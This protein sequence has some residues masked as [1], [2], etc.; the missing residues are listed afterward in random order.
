MTGIGYVEGDGS[1]GHMYLYHMAPTSRSYG[2]ILIGVEGSKPGAYDQFGHY[3]GP[4]ADSGDV[5]PTGGLKWRILG[6][7]PVDAEDDLFVD[8]SR[9]SNRAGKTVMN[10]AIDLYQYTPQCVTHQ[11]R[12]CPGPNPAGVTFIPT[13]ETF[14]KWTSETGKIRSKSP[15]TAVDSALQTYL[16]GLPYPNRAIRYANLGPVILVADVY[17]TQRPNDPRTKG[18]K[19]LLQCISAEATR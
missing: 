12:T 2:G 11:P 14:K 17:V 9:Q 7:G 18:V 4:R 15:I 13:L 8:L 10:D 6:R 1:D 19:K 3:H 16:G 5:S